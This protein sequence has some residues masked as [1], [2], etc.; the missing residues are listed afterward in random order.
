M[1]TSNVYTIIFIKLSA[2]EN[3]TQQGKAKQLEIQDK[4]VKKFKELNVSIFN[5]K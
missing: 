4:Y 1:F 3:Q 5:L 2:W